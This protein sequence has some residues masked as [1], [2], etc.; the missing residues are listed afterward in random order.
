MGA[1]ARPGQVA[2]GPEVMISERPIEAEDR[3]VP[4]HR[5]GDLD[6]RAWQLSGGR[7]VSDDTVHDAAAP[8]T[9]AGRTARDVAH[10]NGPALAGHGAQ[11]CATPAR[12][13]SPCAGGSCGGRLPGISGA[14]DD[15]ASAATDRHRAADG[16]SPIHTAHRQRGPVE[17]ERALRRS[18]SRTDGLA[19]HSAEDRAAVAVGVSASAAQ[20]ARLEARQPKL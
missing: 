13:R 8:A 4:G 2:V 9:H 6:P 14:A 15:G 16:S 19:A 7:C 17:H 5:E 10:Q 1:D 3:A 18:T 20:D 11:A 12:A